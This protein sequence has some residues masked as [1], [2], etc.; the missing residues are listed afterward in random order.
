VNTI[1]P[2]DFEWTDR[3]EYYRLS[4]IITQAS[5]KLNDLLDR[6][7]EASAAGHPRSALIKDMIESVKLDRRQAQD[8]IG[9]I[10]RKYNP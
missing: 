1:L 7:Q 8:R 3:A 5:D 10:W 4:K 2:K 9:V 6:L